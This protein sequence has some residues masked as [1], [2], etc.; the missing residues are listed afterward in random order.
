MNPDNYSFFKKVAVLLSS[1]QKKK[2]AGLVVLLFIG[3]LFEMAGLGVLIPA[4]TVMLKP[5]IGKSYP[6]LQPYL[7]VIGNPSQLTLILVGMLSLVLLYI[8]KS[9]FLIFLS[10]K[11]T[12]FNNELSAEIAKK[13]FLGYLQQPYSF[14]LERNSAKLLSNI[15]S[16]VSLLQSAGQSLMVLITEL[17]LFIS[18]LFIL[19]LVEPI[20]AISVT[21]FLGLFA[22]LFYYFTKGKLNNW[23]NLRLIFAVEYTKHLY[24]GL[25]GVKDVKLLGRENYFLR[26][27][28]INLDK[29]TKTTIKQTT[30]Q[31]VP[32]YYLEVLAVSGLAALVTIT[33]IQ[34][35]PI[36]QLIPVIGL[37]V[38]AAF[39][40]I[41]S[42]NRIMGSIQTIQ[43]AKPA[44]N[45]L[46]DEIELFKEKIKPN[47]KSSNVKFEEAISI[48]NLTM[49]YQN[50]NSDAIK[51]ISLS[52]SKGETI[53]FIG[54]SG[55]G[56]ST[57]VDIILGLL[58]PSSGKVL[59][60]NL[61]I[62]N[63]LRSWQNILGYVPQSIYL[64]DDTLRN[65]IAFGIANDEICEKSV[66]NSIK[67]AQ[68]EELIETLPNGINTLVGERGVR[69]SGGQ[70]QRIGI[71][72]ALYNNPSV[73]ILDEATSALDNK[74]ESEVMKAI[75]SL[76]RSKT[77]IIVAHRL[78]TVENCD[79]I[80]RLVE[81]RIDAIGKPENMIKAV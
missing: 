34:S 58:T 2:L 63:N 8:L 14:H 45:V 51:S 20:G 75:F 68:L 50:S 9:T 24:Q 47:N 15:Q 69:L 49:R 73:L 19:I 78:S 53:G 71:A 3:I 37:F 77:I 70:R 46:Y 44:V 40:M 31:Q 16:E 30:L 60:D 23:G 81:G 28:G 26:E 11:Q 76:K 74:T 54:P 18:V 33:V 22:F 13:L 43:F 42:V 67:A 39:R 21:F 72:R 27:M 35:K 56:K 32:R 4:V 41:P 59:V 12:K 64:T 80:Y 79:R 57:L 7:N 10:W 52:I 1:S 62:K 25:G 6:F 38:A 36:D 48:E 17:S 55:S 61:D 65:N 66:L 29:I 5:D